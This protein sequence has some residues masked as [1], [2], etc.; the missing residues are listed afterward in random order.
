[1]NLG[2]RLFGIALLFSLLAPLAHSEG[3]SPKQA[4]I[5]RI[6]HSYSRSLFDDSSLPPPA[7]NAETSFVDLGIRKVWRFL[8]PALASLSGGVQSRQAYAPRLS[9]RAGIDFVRMGDLSFGLQSFGSFA[10]GRVGGKLYLK[11]SIAQQLHLQGGLWTRRKPDTFGMSPNA[12]ESG[13]EVG[14]RFSFGG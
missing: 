6:T 11:Q 1:M 4:Y 14:V 13:F 9:L 8:R 12:F 5:S 10:N 7:P 3:I 2:L